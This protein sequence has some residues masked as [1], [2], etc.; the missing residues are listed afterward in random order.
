MSKLRHD[1]SFHFTPFA[2][3]LFDQLVP[4]RRDLNVALALPVR[5]RRAVAGRDQQRLKLLDRRHKVARR[6]DLLFDQ[7]ELALL[8][9]LHLLQVLRHG[10]QGLQKRDGGFA[11]HAVDLGD[12]DN[13]PEQREA[14][15]GDEKQAAEYQRRDDD[16]NYR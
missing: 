13:L 9:A 15:G 6:H 4:L 14:D 5:G 2:L 12:R 16:Q 8:K 3:L 1:F 10:L 7:I 11:G